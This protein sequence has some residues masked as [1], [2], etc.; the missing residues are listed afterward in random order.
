MTWLTGLQCV[1]DVKQESNHKT[2]HTQSLTFGK[3][4]ILLSVKLENFWRKSE[5]ALEILK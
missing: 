3:A 1:L 2:I 5:D 4:E